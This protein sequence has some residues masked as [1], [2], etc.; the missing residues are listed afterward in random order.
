VVR[1]GEVQIGRLAGCDDGYMKPIDTEQ[2]E[3]ALDL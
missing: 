1:Y 3:E 2:L